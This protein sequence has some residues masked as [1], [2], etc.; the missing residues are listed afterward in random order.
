MY[1][2]VLRTELLE[3]LA[4][5]T[6][7]SRTAKQFDSTEE[8]RRGGVLNWVAGLVGVLLLLLLLLIDWARELEEGR[9]GSGR[10]ILLTERAQ[11]LA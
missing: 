10:G 11:K 7:F 5:G 3:D 1:F 2:T 8:E 6:S 4:G 9:E